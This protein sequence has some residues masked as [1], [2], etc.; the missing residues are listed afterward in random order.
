MSDGLLQ[1]AMTVQ[2]VVFVYS[3]SDDLPLLVEALKEKGEFKGDQELVI[4]E[5]NGERVIARDARDTG[6]IYQ[7]PEARNTW[8]KLV[9]Q[10]SA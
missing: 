10:R 1:D 4:V 2:N 6:K 5:W 7:S 8:R 3:A 9:L